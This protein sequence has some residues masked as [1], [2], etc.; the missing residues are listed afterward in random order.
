MALESHD[1]ENLLRDATAYVSR[2]QL[3]FASSR[4]FDEVFVG[5]HSTDAV[6]FYFDQ[7]PVYHFN[8]SGMLRRAYVDDQLFKAERGQ[9][10]ALKRQR[11]D[12]EA[13]LVRHPLSSGKQ[14]TFCQSVA[15]QL[16]EFQ[17]SLNNGEHHIDGMITERSEQDIVARVM[18]Y[19]QQLG[20]IVVAQSSRVTA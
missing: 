9:L 3:I 12:R 19:L 6:S 16:A 15:T 14:T 1:R 4:S 11:N 8:K 18:S 17:A 7:D 20:D 2:V 5:F 13:T 10:V